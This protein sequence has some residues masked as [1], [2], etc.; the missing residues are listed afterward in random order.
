MELGFAIVRAKRYPLDL[1]LLFLLFYNA[2]F[3]I[4]IQKVF[5]DIL[6][7]KLLLITTA[8]LLVNYFVKSYYLIPKNITL[9][10]HQDF[11][12]VFGYISTFCQSWATVTCLRCAKILASKYLNQKTF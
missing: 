5:D 10:L 12:L 8:T 4:S 6:L 2:I 3:F 1:L 9:S 7:K 11:T